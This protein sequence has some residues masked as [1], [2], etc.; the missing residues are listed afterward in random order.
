M[1]VFVVAVAIVRLRGRGMLKHD[2]AAETTIGR[3][4][5]AGATR[6]GIE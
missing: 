2:D 4:R 5:R 3:Q 6:R 1:D